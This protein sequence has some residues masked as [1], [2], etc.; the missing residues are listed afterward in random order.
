MLDNYAID[1]LTKAVK[2]IGTFCETEASGGIDAT[3]IKDYAETE[4]IT[5]Q[6]VH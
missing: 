3:T 1:D 5:F 6:W 2:L 4:L